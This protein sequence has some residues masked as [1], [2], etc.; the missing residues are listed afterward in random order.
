[1]KQDVC[2]EHMVTNLYFNCYCELQDDGADAARIVSMF[3]ME[4]GETGEAEEEADDNKVSPDS[5]NN[6]LC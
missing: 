6:G 2:F 1:M 5:S 3:K 4:F